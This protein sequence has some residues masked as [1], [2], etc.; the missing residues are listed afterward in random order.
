MDAN[1]PARLLRA[2]RALDPNGTGC[3]SSHYL[4]AP[5]RLAYPGIPLFHILSESVVCEAEPAAGCQGDCAVDDPPP[6]SNSI[7]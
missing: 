7:I 1:L 3:L 2:C 4:V 5:I 6:T